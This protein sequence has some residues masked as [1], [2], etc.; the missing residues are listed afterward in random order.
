M[1]FGVNLLLFSG[2]VDGEVLDRFGLIKEIGFDGVEIP[3]FEPGSME[4]DAIRRRAEENDLALTACGALPQATRFYGEDPAPREAAAS[5]LKDTVR[6][7][8]ELGAEI[9]CGP[10]YKPVGDT[11]ESLP[12]S[13][14]REETAKRMAPL[15]AEAEE[16]GVVLA[17][18]PLNRFETNLV[19][20]AEQGVE[21]CERVGTGAAKLLLDTFHMHIEEKDSAEAL[22]RAG[23]AG[24]LAHFHASENDRGVAGSGQ[25]RWGEVARALAGASY[26][27]WVV[28]ESFSQSNEAIRTAVSCWR[29]FYPSPEEF[30]REGLAFV[31]SAL[32]TK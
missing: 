11:D 17:F 32:Q 22:R 29:P 1:T 24:L 9:I 19:N 13:R 28:L 8:A 23:S 6:V 3:I 4:V 5:Y 16:K 26:D 7:V 12:L 25:V 15:A 27:G 18:E 14:Q 30:M 10:L 21:F 31:Q 20:T 2:T